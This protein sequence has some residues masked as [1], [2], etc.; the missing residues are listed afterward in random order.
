MLDLI[1][2]IF[3]VVAFG[4]AIVVAPNAPVRYRQLVAAGLL[5]VTLIPLIHAVQTAG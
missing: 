4:A 1:L 3:A 2:F 5:L